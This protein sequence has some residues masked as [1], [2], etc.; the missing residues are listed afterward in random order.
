MTRIDLIP[1]EVVE[2]HKSRR[3][4]A[5]MGIV[6]A[7]VFGVALAVYLITLAQA[8]MASER[9]DIIKSENVKVQQY[10]EKLKPYQDRKKALDERQA[11]IVKMT[12]NQVQWSS[13]LNDISMVVPNDIWLKSVKVDL[14]EILTA[15]EASGA[16]A[17]T[18]PK[19]PITIIGY[20]FNHA[21]VARWLVHLNEINQFRGVWL[22]YATEQTLAAETTS[23]PTAVAAQPVKVIE[24][25]TTVYLTKFKETSTTNKATP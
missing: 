25:Q 8:M 5:L 6:F 10:T 13:I 19:P 12:E 3:I 18:A 24:F 9:V 4:I 23:A 7:A 1:P 15:K 21:A 2:K 11:I 14:G 20:A 22:D 16:A 17:K